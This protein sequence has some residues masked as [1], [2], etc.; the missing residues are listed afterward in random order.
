MKFR[1][2]LPSY[3]YLLACRRSNFFLGKNKQVQIELRCIYKSGSL[4]V[5][6]I[7]KEGPLAV[8]ALVTE[9]SASDHG[10]TLSSINGRCRNQKRHKEELLQQTHDKCENN[11]QIEKV[12][13]KV[14]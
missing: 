13:V 14:K 12:K 10:I 11:K 4:T 5:N 6:G 1:C 9:D 7:V 2:K 8:L 3:K